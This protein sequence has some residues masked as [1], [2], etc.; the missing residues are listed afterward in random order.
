MMLAIIEKGMTQIQPVFSKI[1]LIIKSSA[2]PNFFR[3]A[4][5]GIMFLIQS[6]SFSQVTSGPITFYTI[7]LDKQLVARDLKNKGKVVFSGYVD[8]SPEYQTIKITVR[9]LED[10]SYSKEYSD[11]LIYTVGSASFSIETEIDA[12]FS[13]HYFEIE[14][15]KGGNSTTIDLPVGY[16]NDIV[17]GDV[18]IIQGQSNAE[19]RL[20]DG[21]A[22]TEENNFIRVYASGTQFYEESATTSN[23]DNDLVSN[24]KWYV[25]DADGGREDNGNI[26]QWGARLANRIRL[27]QGVPIAV[28]NGA[29]GGKPIQYFL[30]N[31]S[32][33]GELT[34]VTNNYFRLKYRLEKTGLSNDVKAIFWS[35]GENTSSS[36]SNYYNQFLSL[37][38]SWIGNG[39]GDFPNIEFIYIF[40]TINGCNYPDNMPKIMYS[41]EAQRLLSNDF[42]NIKVINVDG[43]SQY[44]DNGNFCHFSYINGYKDFADRIFPFVKYDFYMGDNSLLPDLFKSP[45]IVKI[46]LE[47]DV[48]LVIETDQN[49]FVADADEAL[50]TFE[51]ENAN[52]A[53]I[54]DLKISN[55]SIFLTLSNY[56]GESATISNLGALPGV[57]S[58][59]IK[60]TSSAGPELLSFYQ[61]PIDFSG[62]TIWEPSW[63]NG[64]PNSNMNAIIAG[65][66][67]LVNSNFNAKN[68][69]IN[70]G[71][72][73]NF[74]NNTTRTINLKGDLNVEGSMIVGDTE[75]LIIDDPNANVVVTGSF[76]KKEKTSLLNSNF[77]VTYWSSPVNGLQLN[78]AFA[79]E[80]VDPNRIFHYVPDELNPIYIGPN[81]IKYRHWFKATGLM[82]PGKGYSVDGPDDAGYPKT[83]EYYFSGLPNFEDIDVSI[84]TFPY[85]DDSDLTN[86]LGNPFPSAIDADALIDLNI[87]KFDGT[88]YFWTHASN[89]VSGEYEDDYITYTKAGSNSSEIPNPYYIASGQ[90]FMILANE[91]SSTFR[92]ENNIMQGG[93]NDTFFKSNSKTKNDKEKERDRIWLEIANDKNIKK[94]ILIGFEKAAT[95]ELDTGYDGKL[96]NREIPLT[97][98]SLIG[99]EKY[100]VQSLGQL[101]GSKNIK[102]GFDAKQVGQ[103]HIGISRLEGQLRD[104]KILLLDRKLKVFHDLKESDYYFKENQ[105][106]E[107]KDRFR[108]YFGVKKEFENNSHVEDK[109]TIKQEDEQLIVKATNTIVDLRVYDIMGNILIKRKANLKEINI[110]ISKVKK[111][112][113]LIINMNII[114]GKRVSKKIVI[115]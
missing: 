7:P 39:S 111:G 66:F 62:I 47:D 93:Q 5:F 59:L 91:G 49:L 40:Q 10:G 84:S 105:Q 17:A 21:S 103:Y 79:N 19:A 107:F 31:N 78:E 28:F 74:D 38:D 63:T 67:N 76:T 106:G 110:N 16:G 112:S 34:P 102:I 97:F 35:Q 50:K 14:L 8:N 114:G 115:N 24:N 100:A 88:L 11:A 108:L 52:G 81:L 104:E 99:D 44:N 90:G 58:N 98:Y 68:L 36:L 60:N 109:I 85:I 46:Y 30:E 94:Q 6:I 23:N 86:L 26:G 22:S 69:K 9:K 75:S 2:V 20:Y 45:D 13:N 83:V 43:L 72:V 29:R 61:Y 65:D 64:N 1:D 80:G 42:T 77:S 4:L 71:A 27:D 54:L 51:L 89:Y 12:E 3:I 57:N 25:A 32:G 113:I 73:F 70:T 37:V 101:R 87:S 41:K 53:T 82:N 15:I 96:I 55:K 92:F 33:S 48:T 95:D 56:P 18:F